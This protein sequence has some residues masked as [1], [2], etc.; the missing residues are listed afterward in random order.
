[1]EHEDDESFQD[2]NLLEVRSPSK[3]PIPKPST[4]ATAQYAVSYKSRLG[5]INSEIAQ[6][7]TDKQPERHVEKQLSLPTPWPDRPPEY[8]F[9]RE[10]SSHHI[11]DEIPVAAR[12][13]SPDLGIKNIVA[14]DPE[15]HKKPMSIHPKWLMDKDQV[16]SP[17]RSNM[18][19]VN[20]VEYNSSTLKDDNFVSPGH[21]SH[22]SNPSE[23]DFAKRLVIAIDYGTTFT[24]ESNCERLIHAHILC[25]C[26]Y[27]YCTSRRKAC[28]A[29]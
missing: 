2:L 12:S 13:K 25:R 26:C 9:E 21:L 18:D 10:T 24:G 19:I 27:C 5:R 17:E 16:I 15:E 22:T 6:S 7:S 1:M 4:A 3:P 14:E 11:Q 23:T 8:H 20:L 28:Q 29:E